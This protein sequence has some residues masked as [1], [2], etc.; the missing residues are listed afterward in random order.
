[1]L[2]AFG[3]AYASDPFE[4]VLV[5]LD[6]AGQPTLL[7]RGN[8]DLTAMR[9]LDSDGRPEMIGRPTLPQGM[10][11]CA[12]TYDPY[13]VYRLGSRPGAKP[14]YDLQL[15]RIYNE[16]HYVWAGPRMSEEVEVRGC[17]PRKLRLIDH[18]KHQ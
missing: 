9:D 14:A 6:D 12:A 15:S 8:F 7:F 13:A 1:M 18:R 5:G 11:E 16:A 3:Y 2:M 17:P 10:G 4:L